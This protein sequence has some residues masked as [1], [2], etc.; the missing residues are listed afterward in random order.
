MEA[1]ALIIIIVIRKAVGTA[2]A[3]IQ[4]DGLALLPVGLL[5]ACVLEVC[6]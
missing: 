1:S 2:Y 3:R 4:N 6:I 5:V